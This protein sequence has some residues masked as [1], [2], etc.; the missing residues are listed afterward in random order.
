M[1]EEC[2]IC[3][4]II[5]NNKYIIFLNDIESNCSC[6]KNNKIHK[7]CFK[8]WISSKDNQLLC[9]ICLNSISNANILLYENEKFRN[10][11]N[12]LI[13]NIENNNNI[14]IE[15]NNTI[16]HQTEINEQNLELI[17]NNTNFRYNKLR[18]C[19]S[20]YPLLFLLFIYTLIIYYNN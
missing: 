18:L 1:I 11:N 2:I 6:M 8:E 4:D 15:D 19:I 7:K 9:P 14:I 16:E 10:I 3:L 13:K 5:N 20:M 17:E 12:Y